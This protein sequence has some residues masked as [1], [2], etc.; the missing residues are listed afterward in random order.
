MSDRLS[1]VWGIVLVPK[2]KV[3]REIRRQTQQILTDVESLKPLVK[4][5]EEKEILEDTVRLLVKFMETQGD[6]RKRIEFECTGC[7]QK[8]MAYVDKEDLEPDRDYPL[9][10]RNPCSK[11]GGKI[12]WVSTDFTEIGIE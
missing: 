10:T 8:K 12:E 6:G 4:N 9:R 5:E 3:N 2:L 7:R 1:R 11:C